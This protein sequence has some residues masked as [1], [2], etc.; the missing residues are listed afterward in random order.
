[1]RLGP[2]RRSGWPGIPEALRAAGKTVLTTRVHPSASIATRAA[3]LKA[4]LLQALPRSGPRA[5]LIAHSLGG[6]DARH[7]LTHLGMSS[8]IEAL[9]TVSSP[10]RGASLAE[11]FR[12]NLHSR[13][14]VYAAI[15]RLLDISAGHELTRDRVARFN[16]TT[17]NHSDVG[18]Y[19][20]TCSAPYPDVGRRYLHSHAYIL[21][22]EGDNDG[23][24]SVASAKWGTHLA[25]WSLGHVAAINIRGIW[26]TVGPQIPQ[27]YAAL[28]ES[29][30]S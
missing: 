30:P 4:Q 19:S 20:V 29:I 10:H 21:D 9:I 17:P 2:L 16:E 6:L 1:M 14:P 7:M 12:R 26:G 18:Y 27:R 13:V 23:V 28:V 8:H 24:V 15:S 22:H 11:F 3:Q 25:H 5:I